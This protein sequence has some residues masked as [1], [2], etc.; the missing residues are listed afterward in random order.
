M[1]VRKNKVRIYI[2]VNYYVIKFYGWSDVCDLNVNLFIVFIYDFIRF[3]NFQ[4]FIVLWKSIFCFSDCIKGEIIIK[5][6]IESFIGFCKV[7]VNF[8][9]LWKWNVFN[10]IGISF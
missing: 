3:K 1:L 2:L 6:N 5:N 7:L 10:Y 9:R 4:V 8:Y